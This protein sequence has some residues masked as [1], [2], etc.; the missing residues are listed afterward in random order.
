[1]KGYTLTLGVYEGGLER[2]VRAFKFHGVRR[3]GGLFG[4]TLAAELTRAGWQPDLLCPVPL[5]PLRRFR[6]GYNQSA[7]VARTAAHALGLPYRPMLNRVRRTEQQARLG[8]DARQ[9]NVAGAFRSQPLGGEHVL[10]VDDVVTS[11][12]TATECSLALFE[13]GASRVYV[14]ALARARRDTPR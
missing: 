4:R 14:A 7:L 12:A 3:L 1:M 10:L 5:H 11:G 13:A 9:H 2:A 6:R 8:K